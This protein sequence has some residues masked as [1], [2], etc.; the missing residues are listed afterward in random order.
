[1][2]V[3][4]HLSEF[5]EFQQ[6][7]NIMSLQEVDNFIDFLQKQ[8]KTS[9]FLNS[10]WNQIKTTGQLS[11]KQ[12]DGVNNSMSY[13]AKV[14]SRDKQREDSKDIDPSGNYVGQ[15]KTRYDMTLKLISSKRT[16]R[17][18]YIKTFQDRNG[19][20]LIQFDF[21]TGQVEC[22]GCIRCNDSCHA[23]LGDCVQVRAT[24]NRH[25]INDFNPSEKIKQTIIN[26]VKYIKNL[27][28]KIPKIST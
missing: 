13:L 6:K 25:S 16:Q 27:G 22:N 9:V 28:S 21:A 3:S 12:I 2:S 20:E 1:M 24:V 4:I 10:I 18:F 26:R 5:K 15:L 19:N 23:E 17:G 7:N 8:E 11:E 14:A